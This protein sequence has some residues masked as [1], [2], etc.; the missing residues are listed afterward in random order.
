M[1]NNIR[2]KITLH[3][4][5]KYSTYRIIVGSIESLDNRYS[6]L[7]YLWHICGS[8]N[9]VLR[10][11]RVIF[12]SAAAW[13]RE[14][15][16]AGALLYFSRHGHCKRLYPHL[17]TAHSALPLLVHLSSISGLRKWDIHVL[18]GVKLL[19]YPVYK[20]AFQSLQER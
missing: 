15:E 11:R 1:L 7:V 5:I 13:L 3:V 4:D 9:M 10:H 16:R 8:A 19:T 20:G 17:H 18:V 12:G 2:K 6:T 14:F